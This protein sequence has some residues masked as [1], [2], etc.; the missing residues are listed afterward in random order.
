MGS[1]IDLTGKVFE[2]LTVVERLYKKGNEWYWRCK[3]QCGNM[4]E[5]AGVSLRRGST[6]SCGCLKREKDRLPKGNAKNEIG[7]K[8]GHLTV[9]R[10]AGSN[11]NGQAQWECECD[12]EAKTHLIVLGNNLRRGHH[13]K[14]IRPKIW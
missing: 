1:F 14:Q 10:R 5:V 7:N 9:I 4:V 13:E 2:R 8:Y 3:C 11:S 12:C 6:K